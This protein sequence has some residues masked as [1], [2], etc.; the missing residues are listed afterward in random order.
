MEVI[1]ISVNYG[2]LLNYLVRIIKE[3]IDIKKR[4]II[5]VDGPDCSGKS[6]LCRSL[7]GILM[8]NYT[9]VLVHFDDYLN[10][11]EIREKRGEFS[12]EGFLYDFFDE[13]AL[14]KSII[15]PSKENDLIHK[16]YPEIIIVE[17]LFLLRPHL[18]SK[19]DLRIRLE[20]D[21]ELL[22][23]RA[24]QRD[25][26]V[27]GSANWV[28]KHYTQQCIPAQKRYREIDK[29]NISSHIIVNVNGDND[30]EIFI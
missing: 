17:G 5:A 11:K 1:M 26:G 29:P 18:I 12:V 20:I 2:E 4:I 13:G 3:K 19:Y 16:I 8:K 6:T 27:L 10:E 22:L 23:K 14:L 7:N 24:M 28:E 30:Y 25:T 15:N 21:D 9:S